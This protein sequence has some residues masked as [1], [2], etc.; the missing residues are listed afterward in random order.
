MSLSCGEDDAPHA[1]GVTLHMIL[2][3]VFFLHIFLTRFAI[4][5]LR[6]QSVLISEPHNL[7]QVAA[8]D[9]HQRLSRPTALKE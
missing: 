9:W 4:Q 3:R 5:P 1:V 8:L 6:F 7:N 2:N